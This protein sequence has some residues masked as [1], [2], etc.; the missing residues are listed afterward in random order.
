MLQRENGIRE[1][2]LSPPARMK[3]HNVTNIDSPIQDYLIPVL[4]FSLNLDSAPV[5]SSTFTAYS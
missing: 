3:L 4:A 5:E 1:N 2:E